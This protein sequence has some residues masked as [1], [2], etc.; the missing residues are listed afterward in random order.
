M[1]IEQRQTCAYA[2]IS[3]LQIFLSLL[4]KPTILGVFQVNFFDNLWL[5]ASF[6]FS[7]FLIVGSIYVKGLLGKTFDILKMESFPVEIWILI[8]LE[9]WCCL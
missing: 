5:I 9:C 8:G 4:S 7:S 1:T 2:T 3:I 6:F